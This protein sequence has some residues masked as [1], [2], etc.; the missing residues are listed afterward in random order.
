MNTKKAILSIALISILILGLCSCGFSNET[1]ITD[2]KGE[3]L[4]LSIID[5]T[6]NGFYSYNKKE[7]TFTPV[8]SGAT[9]NT[10]GGYLSSTSTDLTGEQTRYCW[11]GSNDVDLVNLIPQVDGK[12]RFLT[13]YINEDGEMPSEYTLTKYKNRGYTLGVSF[14]FGST[15]NRLFID[16]SNI[17]ETSMAKKTLKD[18][19]TGQLRVYKINKSKQLP[20]ENVDTNL[21]ALLGLE[22]DKKYQIG[23][24]DGT[25]YVDVDL[26]AD[27]TIFEAVS[28]IELSDPAKPTDKGFF[29]IKLPTNLRNGYYY[30]NDIGMFRYTGEYYRQ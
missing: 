10:G 14:T 16:T 22:K 19:S 3:M 5:L 11:C 26:I 2:E 28:D 29:Y 23:F 7:K 13:M 15:G 30:I 12:K 18:A 27:T 4:E 8:M 20:K 17:C 21:N 25:S 6:E 9:G 24:F 1:E